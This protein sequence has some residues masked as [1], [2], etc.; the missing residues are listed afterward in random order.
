MNK[1]KPL[2]QFLLDAVDQQTISSS[3]RKLLQSL[4][5]IIQ[6]NTNDQKHIIDNAQFIYEGIIYS[7]NSNDECSLLIIERLCSYAASAISAVHPPKP[8]QQ[9]LQEY[10]GLQSIN[11]QYR[12]SLRSLLGIIQDPTTSINKCNAESIYN[13]CIRELC[14]D[15]G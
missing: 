12:D 8:L 14:T 9:F 3:H 4:L 5:H 15:E 11:Q 6:H 2:V 10:I 13:S 1:A 7:A